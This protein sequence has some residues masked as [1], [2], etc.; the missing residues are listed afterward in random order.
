MAAHNEEVPV[1]AV[2]ADTKITS[3]GAGSVNTDGATGHWIVHTVRA[4]DARATARYAVN[5]TDAGSVI[6]S[7]A[8]SGTVDTTGAGSVSASGAGSGTVNT[9]GA[10]RVTLIGV[11]HSTGGS[12]IARSVGSTTTGDSSA[13]RPRAVGM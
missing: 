11:P 12:D 9:R 7:G 6:A 4:G 1:T 13:K 3:A 2:I 5:T 8:G 10:G